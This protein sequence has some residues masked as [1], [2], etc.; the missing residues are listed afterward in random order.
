MT[1]KKSTKRALLVSA[2]AMVICFTM[3]LGT[4]F[5]WFTDTE[6]S[7]NNLIKSGT[8]AVGFDYKLGSASEYSTADNATIFNYDKW[9]PGYLE[10]RHIKITN[11]GDLALNYRLGLATTNGN[12]L[13][14]LANVIDVYYKVGAETPNR[15]DLSSYTNA[16]TLKEVLDATHF[17]AG[18]LNTYNEAD[19]FTLVLVMRPEANND[20]QNLQL[21]DTFTVQVYA[22][23]RALESDSIGSDYDT[24]N[25]DSTP[26]DP[27]PNP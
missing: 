12:D 22:T 14:I 2:M 27:L 20:Y 6:T 16:G 13:S 23:Q 25:G 9:E 8:L 1:N 15:D 4:T 19:I 24:P 3:L 7:T 10:Y 5:A 11:E 18:D 26:G 21:G 17:Y